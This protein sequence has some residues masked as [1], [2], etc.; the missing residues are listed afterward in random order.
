MDNSCSNVERSN[1]SYF[2]SF[3]HLISRPQFISF[4]IISYSDPYRGSGLHSRLQFNV[5]H[6]F[7]GNARLLSCNPLFTTLMFLFVSTFVVLEGICTFSSLHTYT[8]YK[9]YPLTS[10]GRS[11]WWDQTGFANLHSSSPLLQS[12]SIILR[13]SQTYRIAQLSVSSV[14]LL[15][16]SIFASS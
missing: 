2:R 11:S 12:L 5:S 3:F 14:F 6:P 8:Y 16:A 7:P 9:H 10:A 13:W 4:L 15:A 1:D